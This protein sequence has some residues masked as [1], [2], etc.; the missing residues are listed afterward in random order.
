MPLSFLPDF[1]GALRLLSATAAVVRDE[2]EVL[3]PDARHHRRRRCGG[4][5]R[6]RLLRRVRRLKE[7]SVNRIYC[8]YSRL[9]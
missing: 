2:H 7:S 8:L 5:G 6:L 3:V 9:I 4:Q 1:L